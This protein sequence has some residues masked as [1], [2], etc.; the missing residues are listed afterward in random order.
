MC[1]VVLLYGY[2]C[3]CV[4]LLLKIWSSVQNVSTYPSPP[5]AQFCAPKKNKIIS[6][7]PLK[8][9]LDKKTTQYIVCINLISQTKKS[10]R[11]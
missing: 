11:V 8:F 4:C 1:A 3:M 10:V 5:R 2:V 7:V 6:L 9:T